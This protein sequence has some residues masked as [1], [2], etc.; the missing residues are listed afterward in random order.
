MELRESFGETVR[1]IRRDKGL[2]QGAIG[3][4]QGYVSEV[5][6]GL[7]SPTL[8]KIAE[9]ASNLGLHPLTLLTVA[10]EKIGADT[11]EEILADVASEIET[12]KRLRSPGGPK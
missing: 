5:E 1:S 2:P 8:Q 9:I 7:K 3:A 10:F 6:N 12:L 4:N 11:A